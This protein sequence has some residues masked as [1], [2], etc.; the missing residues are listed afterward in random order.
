MVHYLNAKNDEQEIN[1]KQF[2]KSPILNR[3]NKTQTGKTLDGKSY[4]Y[5]EKNFP[6]INFFA[7][8]DND[9]QNI[10]NS[11]GS[12]FDYFRYKITKIITAQKYHK[13]MI[14]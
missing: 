11:N 13:S 2:E 10:I 8:K 12:V 3:S 14:T 1:K 6:N 9:I 5:K 4:F 7:P